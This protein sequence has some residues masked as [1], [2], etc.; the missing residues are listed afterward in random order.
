M[1]EEKLKA[2]FSSPKSNSSNFLKR[3]FYTVNILTI[4]ISG[5]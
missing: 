1:N 4:K 5:E 2:A 3:I